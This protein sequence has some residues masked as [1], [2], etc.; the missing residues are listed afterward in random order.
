MT[1][2]WGSLLGGISRETAPEIPLDALLERLE[3]GRRRAAALSAIGIAATLVIAV[4]FSRKAQ[5]AP[6]HLKLQGVTIDKPADDRGADVPSGE[7]EEFD[8]P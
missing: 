5:D 8:R 3:H 1:D 4:A 2:E 7:P 6:V